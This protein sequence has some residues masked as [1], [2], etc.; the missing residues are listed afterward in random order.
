MGVAGFFFGLLFI[1]NNIFA[2]FPV[3]FVLGKL[4]TSIFNPF[5]RVDKSRS[6][7]IGGAGLGLALVKYIA[8]LHGGS[9]QVAKS[10][11]KGTEIKL[12]G[13]EV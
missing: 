12:D 8:Q 11:E 1:G 4:R 7:A 6:R 2:A 13:K 5:V 10:S 9:V 3:C